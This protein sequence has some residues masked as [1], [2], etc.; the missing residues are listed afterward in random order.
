[1]TSQWDEPITMD[2]TH[3][4]D[5]N[6]NWPDMVNIE[7]DEDDLWPSPYGSIEDDIYDDTNDDLLD[8]LQ[9]W[10]QPYE[11]EYIGWTEDEYYDSDRIVLK[12]NELKNEIFF[13]YAQFDSQSTDK[14]LHTISTNI[15]KIFNNNVQISKIESLI[16]ANNYTKKMLKDLNRWFRHACAIL[17][18]ISKT[19]VLTSAQQMFCNISIHIIN[20]L[21][22]IKPLKDELMA[23]KYKPLRIQYII[24]NYGIEALDDY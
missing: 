1:M 20:N 5:Q 11:T 14:S 18:N 6:E 9:I 17:K 21:N 13:L 15:N 7:F 8:G 10:A 22:P 16:L 23:E 4:E 12:I 3:L 19:I 24:D 2:F